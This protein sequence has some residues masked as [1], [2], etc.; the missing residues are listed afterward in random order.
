MAPPKSSSYFITVLG[1]KGGIGKTILSANLADSFAHET[2]GSVL[3]VD[4]DIHGSGD[5]PLLLGQ[6]NLTTMVDLLPSLHKISSRDFAGRSAGTGADSRYS[7]A[8]TTPSI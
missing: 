8:G 1:G 2:R 7:L 6:K 4:F 3:L 5:I